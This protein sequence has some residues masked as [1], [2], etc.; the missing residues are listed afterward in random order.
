MRQ[1]TKIPKHPLSER[2]ESYLQVFL[3]SFCVMLLLML[4]VMIFSGGYFVYYGDFNS[5]QLPFYSLARRAVGNGELGWNWNTDLGANFI[6][7]YS[8]YLIG[9]PFFWLTMLFPS[10]WVLYLMPYLLALKH[11]FAALTAYAYIRRFVRNRN[12]ALI[13]GLLYAFSGFQLYNVF[14]NHF[15]DVT[16]F[17]PLLL[18]AMEQRVNE[19]RRGVL[20]LSVALMG[21][22]NYYFFTG[23]AVFL[24][25]YFIVRCPCKDFDVTLRKFFSVALEAVLGVMMAAFMLLPSALAIIDN[26]RVKQYLWG[27]DMVAYSDRTRIWRIIQSFFMLPDVPA[28]PNLFQSDYGKWS[29][30]GGFLPLF[31]MAGVIAFMSQKKKHW[32]TRLTLICT[33]CAFIPVLNSMFYMFNA[34]YYAR[35]FYMPVLIMAMM[36]AYA[37]DNPKIKWKGGIITCGIFLLGFGIISLLPTKDKDGNLHFFEFAQFSWYFWLVLGL[38]IIM[39]YLTV[40]IALMR[41]KGKRFYGVAVGATIFCCACSGFGMIYFGLGLGAWPDAYI[42]T[43]IRG[44]ESISLE[45]TP[46]QFYRIDISKDYDNYPMIWG[47]SNM[48]CFHSIV[49]TSIMDFYDELD[50]TRDVASRPEPKHYGLRELFSVRYYFDKFD[51]EKAK[52]TPETLPEMPSFTYLK[53]ENGF[54]IY[55]NEAYIPMGLAYDAYISEEDLDKYNSQGKEKIMVDALV[56]SQEQR[57]KYADIL[58]PL[59]EDQRII[60]TDELFSV[61]CKERAAET[62]TSF[63]HDSYGFNAKITLEHPKMVFFSVPYEKGWSAKVNGKE[64]PVEKV[65]VGFMAVRCEAGANEIA[66]SY[67][68]PG[69]KIG[70]VIAACGAA[71]LIAYLILMF[72]T[73]RGKRPQTPKRKYCYDYQPYMPF[74]EHTLYLRYAAAKH[75]ESERIPYTPPEMPEELPE[76][77]PEEHSPQQE[78]W[79]DIFGREETETPEEPDRSIDI[80]AAQ[81]DADTSASQSSA[82]SIEELLASVPPLPQETETIP[83]PEPADADSADA[84]AGTEPAADTGTPEEDPDD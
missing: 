54:N 35:W 21:V 71:G 80:P 18:I 30:I 28:R 10:S 66:F 43:A 37:L 33:V 38:C 41:K 3:I 4:P 65:N 73:E 31:S 49:P 26:F 7:S 2:R 79:D 81:D 6:G 74:S 39:L 84:E 25:L 24:I 44:G 13:G 9:S 11:A 23:Q 47:Y 83:A 5:Q 59:S 52:N 40:L 46:D 15:Q 45:E 60:L 48:R 29:S 53:R 50:I 76:E 63:T 34:S 61:H 78:F 68:T 20:A 1:R 17:F 27:M 56:L 64:V 77:L 8:F 22:I 19:N 16:A 12:A 36:T 51:S 14:F 58:S 32:A 42:N 72:V 67:E 69:L 62:C 55:E 70:L 75:P 82:L 57:E